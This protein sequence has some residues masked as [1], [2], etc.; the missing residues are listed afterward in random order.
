MKRLAIFASGTGSNAEAIAHH[1][2][3]SRHEVGILVTNNPV[4]GVLER[5]KRF[6]IK[7]LL[8]S[9]LQVPLEEELKDEGIDAIALAGYLKLIPKALIKAYPDR[10]WNIHPALLPAYGGKGMYGDRI[11]RRVLKDGVSYTGVT[12][13]AVNEKYDEGKIL[14]QAAMRIEKEWNL[15]DLAQHIHRLEHRYYP[16]VLHL[17]LDDL[18]RSKK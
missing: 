7:S 3:D 11:H 6:K 5:L 10:I 18:E 9:D 17:L 4:A 12:I 14:F 16:E 2:A 8:T 13:H 15:E 1:L